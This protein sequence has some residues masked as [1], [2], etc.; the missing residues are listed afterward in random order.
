MHRKRVTNITDLEPL[1]L[2][3]GHVRSTGRKRRVRAPVAGNG[4][5][6]G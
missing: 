4:I 3:R 1:D 2:N 5:F 6:Y